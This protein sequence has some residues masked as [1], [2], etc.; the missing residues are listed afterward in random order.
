MTPLEQAEANTRED[1]FDAMRRRETFG[2]SGPRLQVR[3]FVGDYGPDITASPDLLETAYAG[4][5]PMG[6]NWASETGEAPD[7]LAW[8]VRDPLSAPLQRLQIVKVSSEGGNA[9][10]A[11]FDVACSGDA[12]P[13]PRSHRCPDNGASVD[14]TTCETDPG[15]GA[16]Q[17]MARWTDPTFEAGQAAAYYVRVLENPTCRWSTWDAVRAGSE[18]NPAFPATLQERAWSSPIWIE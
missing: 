3:F 10:E 18:P 8:A 7:F 11:V 9:R 12:Q 14:T 15:T 6:G 17:L 13:D 1:L 2:T 5:V 4:G 16:G